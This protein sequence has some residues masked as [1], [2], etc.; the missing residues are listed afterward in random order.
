MKRK[1][2]FLFSCRND[3]NKT[4]ERTFTYTHAHSKYAI[5]ELCQQAT[6]RE[7][8]YYK[9][10][11]QY[12]GWCQLCSIS[13]SILIRFSC[14]VV[15]CFICSRLTKAL[16]FSVTRISLN[17][18]CLRMSINCITQCIVL[19]LACLFAYLPECIHCLLR[20]K[21]VLVSLNTQTQRIILITH[22]HVHTSITANTIIFLVF[23]FLFV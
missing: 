22:T 7:Q 12:V 16:S 5:T 20:V 3:K 23:V 8:H 15:V 11:G 19:L 1:L 6:L 10:N 17:R 21:S 9:T 4:S 2:R 13:N 18:V 14:L